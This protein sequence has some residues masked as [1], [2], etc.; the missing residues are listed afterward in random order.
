MRSDRHQR[1][2]CEKKKDRSKKIFVCARTRDNVRHVPVSF[3][4][5]ET[6]LFGQCIDCVKD[7]SFIIRRQGAQELK[8]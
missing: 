8:Y 3:S 1:L 5:F 6:G 4:P 7:T 2:S